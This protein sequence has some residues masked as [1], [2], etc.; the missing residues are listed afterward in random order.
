MDPLR[1]LLLVDNGSLR[2][3]ATL[4][5]RRLAAAVAERTGVETRPV[6]LLHSSGVAAADLGGEPAVILEPFLRREAAAGRRRWRILPLFL[7]RSGAIVDYVPAR[8]AALRETWP[9]LDVTVAPVLAEATP[10]AEDRLAAML[11]DGVRAAVPAGVRPVVA[12][13]DHGSPAPAVTA[14]RNRLASRLAVALGDVVAGVRAC[15][16][17]RR[18]GPEYAF[19]EPLLET[20]L[21]D[22]AW[23]A[24]VPGPVVV[25]MLFLQPGRH[26]G[27]EGDV[28]E[29]CA[30]AAVEQPD[31]E[32]IRTALLGEH[33]G[34]LDLLAAAAR[35]HG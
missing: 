12:L 5:L 30:A 23:W 7:G 14:L 31:L 8:L 24:G 3:E 18:P 20:V 25:S 11:A 21:R 32:T 22:R 34:L 29:I 28:A 9:D 33:P 13:V 1:P 27:P 15:S 26:A 4:S 19:N 16:M 2:P 35:G 6:S 10:E 17:E